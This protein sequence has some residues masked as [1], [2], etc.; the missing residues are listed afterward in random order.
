MTFSEIFRKLIAFAGE[1]AELDEAPEQKLE[2]LTQRAIELIET[3]DD[4]LVSLLPPGL[5]DLAKLLVDN[6]VVDAP[7]R[8]VAKALAEAAYQAWKVIRDY[9][10]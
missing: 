1:L 10:D 7:E 4:T 9:L 3:T 2:D 5:R 8:E 6:P